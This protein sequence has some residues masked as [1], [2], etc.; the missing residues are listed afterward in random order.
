MATPRAYDRIRDFGGGMDN[1]RPPSA[2]D[3]NQSQYLENIDIQDNFGARTR[4]GADSLQANFAANPVGP[5]QGLSFFNTSQ[6]SQL[7]MGQGGKL[8]M[9][10]GAIWS[11]ALAFA[12]NNAALQFCAAQG[13]DK[14]LISDGVQNLQ[15]YDGAN[16]TDCGN[17]AAPGSLN[18]PQGVTVLCWMGGRMFATG[19]AAFPDTVWVSN[20]LQFGPGQWNTAKQS[21]RVG[22]G[23]GDPVIACAPMQGFN[24]AFL[25]QNSVWL[26]NADP[27]LA[28]ADYSAVDLGDQVGPIGC[29]GRNAWC[30]YQNDVL[31]M[32]QEGVHS[33]QRMQA[34]AGQYQLTAPLSLPLQPYIDRINWNAANLIYAV[35]YRHLAIFYV[36][37]DNSLFNN[38]ALVWNGR[39]GQWSGVWTGWSPAVAAV[40]R[41]NGVFRLVMGNHDGSVTQW[42]DFASNTSDATYLDNGANITTRLW[43]R[44]LVF[45]NPDAQ[46]RLRGTL[47]RFNAGNATVNLTATLDLADADAWVGAVEPLG[48]ILPAVLPILLESFEPTNLYHSLED[49]P[50]SNETYFKIESTAGWWELRNL[51]AVGFLK[52]MNTG[53]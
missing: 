16:F 41:F 36:P 15:V 5:V 26:V 10:N 20:R 25:K 44:A 17:N 11:A 22:N 6:Y 24:L 46:K 42:K 30:Q 3:L 7:L 45:N 43:T 8:Y 52:P 33:V 4:P 40:T 38:Y 39:L 32:S 35:R 28:P 29:V 34:A 23:D 37:L 51:T 31:F 53:A 9:W 48:D 14:L 50:Y 19:V 47:L 13:V 1:Y 18:P 49:L 27:S 2:I 21:F 12:L